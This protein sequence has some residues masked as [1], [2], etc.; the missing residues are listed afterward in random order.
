MLLTE[1]DSPDVRRLFE[2]LPG[3]YIVLTPD[4]RVVTVTDDY[5][6]A[7]MVSRENLVGQY[8]FDVFPDNPDDEKTHNSAS[9]RGSMEKVFQTGEADE[10]PLIRYDVR[11]PQSD[12]GVFEQRFW[13]LITFPRFDENG[14]VAY[15]V[16][17]VED[18]TKHIKKEIRQEELNA[19][20]TLRAEQIESERECTAFALEDAQIRLEAA[21]EAGEIGTWTWD[22]Q[23]NRVVADKNLAHFFSVSTTDASGGQIEKYVAAIHADDRERVGKIIDDALENK[24]SYEAEYRILNGGNI[25]WV[26]ARGKILRDESGAATQLPGVV[27]D[28]TE[29]KKVEV[30]LR[31]SEQRLK[32]ALDAGRLGSYEYN[33]ATGEMIC[34]ERCLANFGLPPNADLPFDKFLSMIKDEDRERVKNAVEKSLAER[35]DYEIEYQITR[36]DGDSAW[37]FARGRGLYDEQGKP[38]VMN[39]VTLDITN[40]KKTEEVLIETNERFNL[41]SRATNDAVWD[42]N[43]QNDYVWWNDAVMTLFGYKKEQVELTAK[44]WYEHIHADDR[45][46]VVSGIHDVI[47]NGG[48]NWS[49]E[50]RFL[51]ADGSFRYVFDRGFAIHR[52]NKPIRMLGAM[53]DVTERRKTEE[54]LKKSQERL[55]LVLDTSILG[56]WYCDLPFD[57]LTWSVQTKEHFWLPPDATVTIEDFYRIIHPEDREKTRLAIDSSIIDR[58]Q[59]DVE[60][61]TVNAEETHVKW[62]RAVGRGF[63]DQNNEPYRFDGITIDISPD[64]LIE[65]EREQLLSN[66]K[67]ARAEAEQANRM[68]DEFL[69]TLSHELRTPL[70]AI[71]GWSRMLREDRLDEAQKPRAVETIERNAKSQAQLIEDVLDVSRIISGKMRLEVKPV[72]LHSI[73][74]AAIDSVRPAAEAKKIRLQRVLDSDAMISGDTDRVQQIFWNLLS[75]AIKFTPKDGKVQIKMERVNSHVEIVVTDTGMGIDAETLPYVFERFR[76]SDSSTTRKFGGLGLGLA[77]VRHL[78]ELHGGTV[79]ADSEGVDCGATFTITFPLIALRS[80]ELPIKENKDAGQR[81]HPTADEENIPFIC[82]DG[83]KDLRILLVDDEQDMREMILF[84]LD[85]CEA[86]STSA[87]SVDEA[88]EILKTEKFDVLISDIGMPERDGYDLIKSVRLLPLEQNGSLPAIALT[89]YARVE[90]RLRA[91]SSGFQ[92]HVPKPIEPAEL[93]A[94]IAS[95]TNWKK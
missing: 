58:T 10:L 66:E 2:T 5:L 21:L 63:Y 64:K 31:E 57:V 23:N 41:I 9:V 52:D 42:W 45:D 55:Q 80:K 14:A 20:L 67:T 43:L 83:I 12:G 81:I 46:R 8:L 49:D 38:F 13:Q 50:Y 3:L 44:W 51:C 26:V 59:Y 48:E 90:D 25:R 34:S 6:R 40:R 22:V 1:K 84:V 29:R 79:H 53:Q 72:D 27:I 82:P 71:L 7:T 15:I 39:G 16:H 28:I 68:K 24:D 19:E 65:T 78:V 85:Y 33:L 11:R 60:Y 92:M 91:L 95:L 89:A 73:I 56:L 69:A 32:F 4:L 17:R 30:N 77:I 62:I 36:A 88:L 61:R 75:N 35:T 86:K 18:V 87:S 70:S 37:I 47:D 54:A 94:V 93:L 76:Q 74:E